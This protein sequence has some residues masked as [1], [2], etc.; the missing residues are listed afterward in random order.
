MRAGC[1]VRRRGARSAGGL[2]ALAV[3]ALLSGGCGPRTMPDTSSDLQRRL[4]MPPVV[5]AHPR[6]GV[7]VAAPAFLDA[8]PPTP[9]AWLRLRYANPRA[10]TSIAVDFLNECPSPSGELRECASVPGCRLRLGPG[11]YDQMV[12]DEC[13]ASGSDT[14][15]W[16][17]NG[18]VCATL[19]YRLS[20]RAPGYDQLRQFLDEFAVRLAPSREPASASAPAPTPVPLPR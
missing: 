6:H 16:D 14:Y 19:I 5:H 1:S 4:Q 10:E 12:D 7:R 8:L 20:S 17:T 11:G 15:W 2:R 9:Q 3:L 13:V 18:I